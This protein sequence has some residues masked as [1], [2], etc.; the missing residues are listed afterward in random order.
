M[1]DYERFFS[2]GGRVLRESP[3]RKMGTVLAASREVI[4]FAPGYPADESFPW[5]AFRAIADDLLRQRSDDLLQ[6]GPTRGYRPLIDAIIQVQKARGMTVTVPQVIVTTGS[7]QGLFLVAR[8]LFDPGDVVLVELPSYTGAITAFKSFGAD[9]VGVAQD[10]DGINLEDLDRTLARVRGEGRRVKCL[11]LVPNFQ[12]PTG[13]LLSLAKRRALVD[14]A[15][16][17]DVLIIEDDP[18]RDIYFTDVTR[19]EDTRPIAADDPNGRVIYLSS[20]SKTL[21]PG[22][23]TAW[24]VAPPVIASKIELAKQAIDL[25]TSGFDQQMVYQACARGVL[26]AQAPKLRALYQRKRDVMVKALREAGTS[27]T[28][29]DPRGGFF[30]WARLPDGLHADTLLEQTTAEGVIYVT[31]SAFFVDATGHEFIRLSFS[32][33]TEARIKEGVERLVGVMGGTGTQVP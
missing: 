29:L 5:D 7:Q 22:F 14:W 30:L 15:E 31:G 8:A 19:E 26:E 20:F 17:E 11:Y 6:Y 3:I 21:A 25:C 16:R 18:Y 28:W 24:L 13:R 27:L 1:T 23:R 9:L 32:S 10:D 12:N 4:S 2:E 33:P